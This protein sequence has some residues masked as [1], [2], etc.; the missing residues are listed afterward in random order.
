MIGSIIGPIIGL[1]TPGGGGG[2]PPPAGLL[3]DFKW[4]NNYIAGAGGVQTI[5]ADIGGVNLVQNT[6]SAQ[7]QDMG[8]HVALDA[9]DQL[10]A[11]FSYSETSIT[12]I[13]KVRRLTSTPSFGKLVHWA[14]GF[15]VQRNGLASTCRV[16]FDGT[17]LTSVGAVVDS[18]VHDLAVTWSASS[19]TLTLYIDGAFDSSAAH[20][21]ANFD[22]AF[23]YRYGKDQPVDIF[24]SRI[25]KKE[26]TPSEVLTAFNEMNP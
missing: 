4:T 5:V 3:P 1:T 16:I 23:G 17:I 24:E 6:A 21:G 25:Y 26:L 10:D 18:T 22:E 20:V 13:Y 8:D 9:D 7:P 14:N 11:S 2:P 12:L 15:Q 19:S